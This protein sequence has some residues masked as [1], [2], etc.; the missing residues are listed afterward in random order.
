MLSF[1]GNVNS[2]GT[3]AAVK[4]AATID[5]LRLSRPGGIASRPVAANI[6][7]VHNLKTRTGNVARS[8]IKL[9]S[10]SA[11]I[12]GS[13][14]LTTVSPTI[15]MAL[16]GPNM[17][18]QELLSFLPVFDIVLPSGATI[19]GGTV[20][21]GA[22]SRGTIEHLNTS[23][24]IKIEKTKLANYDLGSKLKIIQQ[25]AGVSTD[26]STAIDLV[27]A[28]F[29]NGPFGSRIKNIQFVAPSIG[30]LTGEGTVSP[31]HELDFTMSAVVRQ[32]GSSPR[33]SVSAVRPPRCLSSSKALRRTRCSKRT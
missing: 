6:A 25:L 20:T 13:Y 2:N 28:N 24:S 16:A 10:A 26:T 18:L 23:G 1:T 9:G 15:N 3:T 11:E 22:A 4:G 33:P 14:N 8:T 29:E 30:T 19:E 32:V 27:A 5:R 7:L 31:I 17:P 12:S 21:L